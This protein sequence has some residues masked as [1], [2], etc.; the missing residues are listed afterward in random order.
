[1]ARSTTGLA[2]WGGSLGREGLAQRYTQLEM[3]SIPAVLPTRT[4]TFKETSG[5]GHATSV[6]IWMWTVWAIRAA[7]RLEDQS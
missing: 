1:M 4:L 6:T 2:G 5:Q 7:E 3:Q